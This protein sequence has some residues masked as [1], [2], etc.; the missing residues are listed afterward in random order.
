MSN[1]QE[2]FYA[3]KQNRNAAFSF[4]N[5]DGLDAEIAG[6]QSARVHPTPA[7]L[8]TRQ[9]VGHDGAGEPAPES[10]VLEHAGRVR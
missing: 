9:K 6:S 10:S 7:T 4:R 8:D 1:G 2:F 5:S 3:N